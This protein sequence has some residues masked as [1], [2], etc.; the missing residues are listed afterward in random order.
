MVELINKTFFSKGFGSEANP[1]PFSDNI[2]NLEVFFNPSL[3]EAF[4]RKNRKYIGVLPIGGYPLPPPLARIGN[5]RFF[6]WA[7]LVIFFI[8]L[9]SSPRHEKDSV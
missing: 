7:F 5:F 6:P 4:I 8:I 2:Q 3:R 1:P 9:K